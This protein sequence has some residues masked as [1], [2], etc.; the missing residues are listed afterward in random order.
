MLEEMGMMYD[1]KYDDEIYIALY[2]F[3]FCDIM[4]YYI[5]LYI[6]YIIY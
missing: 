5:V 1:I 2:Y 3:T 6:L 4:L